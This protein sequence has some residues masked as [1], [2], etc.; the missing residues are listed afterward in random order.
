MS[1]CQFGELKR[2]VP[3]FHMEDTAEVTETVNPPSN[4]VRDQS[5]NKLL[6]LPV[7][8]YTSAS[9]GGKRILEE[10]MSQKGGYIFRIAMCLILVIRQPPIVSRRAIEFGE[11]A[12]PYAIVSVDPWGYHGEGSRA[13]WTQTC[14]MTWGPLVI[15]TGPFSRSQE[16]HALDV[17]KREAAIAKPG[18]S[19]AIK[20]LDDDQQSGLDV[21]AET[22]VEIWPGC[23]A[24]STVPCDIAR[25]VKGSDSP[26][27]D[28][29]VNADMRNALDVRE[30]K[31]AE[32][33]Q[34]YGQ[35]SRFPKK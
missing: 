33:S 12:N 3:G 8:K 16:T 7:A 34:R 17:A 22:L 5:N 20:S 2:H 9:T 6:E 25:S 19:L 35:V 31:T 10:K 4:F 30:I 28:V 14:E 21:V 11:I 32:L 27:R 1:L 26:A 18:S 15:A 29:L 24:N 13:R 23:K